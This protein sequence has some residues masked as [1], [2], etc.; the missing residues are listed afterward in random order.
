GIL[1]GI[2]VVGD[3]C[4]LVAIAQALAERERQRRLARSDRAADADPHRAVERPAGAARPRGV[5]LAAEVA[6][7][8]CIHCG[9]PGSSV[10]PATAAAPVAAGTPPAPVYARRRERRYERKRREYWVSCRIEAIAS[11]GA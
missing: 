9:V 10:H 7:G 1:A 8:G 4:D 6:G 3:R 11:P 2:D 5:R